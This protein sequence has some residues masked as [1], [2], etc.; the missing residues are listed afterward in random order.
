MLKKEFPSWKWKAALND[1]MHSPSS[2][3]WEEKFEFA[4]WRFYILQMQLGIK[5]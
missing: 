4:L 3:I 2:A 5:T 1:V